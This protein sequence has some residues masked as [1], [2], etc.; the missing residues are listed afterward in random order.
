MPSNLLDLARAR[1]AKPSNDEVSSPDRLST[2][3]VQPSPLA[4]W[5]S[6]MREE[7]G[8]EKKRTKKKIGKKIK[9][10]NKIIQKIKYF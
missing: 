1:L 9:K 4:S 5:W 3:T 2:T 8:A 10:I 6:Q 7:E